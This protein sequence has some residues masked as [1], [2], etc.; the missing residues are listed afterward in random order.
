MI[1]GLGPTTAAGSRLAAC[2]LRRLHRA[3]RGF[4]LTEELISLAVLALAIGVVITGIYTGTVGVRTKHGSVNGQTLA[5]SQVELILDDGYHPDP[6]AAP[7]PTVAPVSGF[8]VEVEVAYWTAPSGPFTNTLRDDGLQR[9]TVNVS[10]GNGQ[11]QQLEA[12]LVDR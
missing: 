11:L 12:Y 2:L 10:D 3:Q 6:T 8:T 7:Y 1:G 5:R 4:S 9:L